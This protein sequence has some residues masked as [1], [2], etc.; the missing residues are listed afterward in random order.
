MVVPDALW[1]LPLPQELQCF[2][3]VE[4]ANVPG[5]QSLQTDTCSLPMN[6]PTAQSVQA[7]V[8]VEAVPDVDTVPRGQFLQ[9]AAPGL[10]GAPVANL[11]CVQSVQTEAPV[12]FACLPGAQSVHMVSPPVAPN[13][14]FPHESQ[15][16]RPVAPENLPAT[17]VPH[18]EWPVKAYLPTAHGV[19][20]VAPAA[21][22]KVPVAQL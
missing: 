3:P 8:W 7:G 6:L 4:S 14:P 22:A 15:E 12:S 11:P 17:H 16:P 19:Q 18:T 20:V 1:Y 10:F 9:V 13:L 21:P 2:L 5:E